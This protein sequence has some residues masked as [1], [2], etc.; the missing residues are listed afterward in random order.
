M[1]PENAIMKIIAMTTA[2]DHDSDVVNHSHRRD[3][4]IQREHDIEK[5]YLNDDAGKRR[6]NLSRGMPFITLE[7]TVNLMCCL[8]K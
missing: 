4:R 3:H 2:R 6:V 8:A 7:R 5:H 1:E